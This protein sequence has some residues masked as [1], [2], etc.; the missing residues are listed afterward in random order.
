MS[1]SYLYHDKNGNEIKE[2][3]VIHIEGEPDNE[4]VYACVSQDGRDNLGIL[5]TNKEYLKYHPDADLEFY[6][7]SNWISE[8]IE[9]VPSEGGAENGLCE[10]DQ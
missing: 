10:K 4:L 7:L 1:N 8:Q 5:A 2:G 3:M 6:P 9:I